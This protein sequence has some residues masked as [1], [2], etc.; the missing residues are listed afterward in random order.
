[1]K[2]SSKKQYLS[3]EPIGLVSLDDIVQGNRS[4]HLCDHLQ[5]VNSKFHRKKPSECTVCHSD[6]IAGVFILGAKNGVLLWQCTECMTHY[7]RYTEKTTEKYLQK[8]TDVWTNP[9]DWEDF[10][11]TKE[12]T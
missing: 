10:P 6:L 7:L 2:K 12:P 9:L 8:A 4:P 1:L 3:K 11:D 5:L